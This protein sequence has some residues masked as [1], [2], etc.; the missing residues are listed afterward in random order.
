MQDLAGIFRTEK[1]LTEAL[2]EIDK[3]KQRSGKLAISGSRMFNPGWH[4]CRDLKSMLTV[5]EAVTCSALARRESRG[6]HSRIDYPNLDP[7]WGK[8][9]NVISRRGEAMELRQAPTLEMPEELQSLLA[10]EKGA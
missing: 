7:V 5:A 9:N 6:A 4:L 10:D 8:Q 2:D 1:D 3:L